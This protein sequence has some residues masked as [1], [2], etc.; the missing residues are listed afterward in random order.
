MPR[1]LGFAAAFN[2]GSN[3]LLEHGVEVWV[4]ASHDCVL[5][6]TALGELADK[7]STVM[8]LVAPTVLEFSNG[9]VFSAGGYIN[10]WTG[11]VGAL[12]QLSDEPKRA[13]WA[14]GSCF[15]IGRE[16]FEATG[17][18]NENFFLYFEDVDLGLRANELGARV[19]VLPVVTYQDP[20]GPS[21]YLR[22][23]SSGVLARSRLSGSLGWS[24]IGR[25]LA[26]ALSSI[27]HGH[28]QDGIS[29]LR[30][31]FQGLAGRWPAY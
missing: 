22:G 28:G 15:A 17:G 19:W 5:S 24:L 11:K 18:M 31:L 1:N 26:G 4:N 30:G 10:Q 13:T 7:A 14:D 27:F 29:R 20:Q 8:T 3:R 21:A 9:D 25:N 6:S 16:L 2:A 23:H 12:T